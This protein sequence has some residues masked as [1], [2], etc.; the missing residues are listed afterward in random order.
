MGKHWRE[1]IPE[2]LKT[3]RIQHGYTGQ[4]LANLT[5]LSVS[6]LSDLERGR[7]IPTIET[8]DKILQVYG[9]TMTIGF[10]DKDYVPPGYVWVKRE[11]LKELATIVSEIIP[12]DTGA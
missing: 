5:G 1:W 11:T 2:T 10:T 6:Y 3:L 8:L 12:K 9:L 7:T 4:E